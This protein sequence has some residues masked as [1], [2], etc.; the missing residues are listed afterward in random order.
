MVIDN[1]KI[2]A[3][4]LAI[5]LMPQNNMQLSAVS[6]ERLIKEAKLIEDYIKGNHK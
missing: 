3:L 1:L 6:A 5:K 4:K 2:K